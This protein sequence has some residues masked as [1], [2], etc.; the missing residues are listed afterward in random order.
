MYQIYILT[1]A[2]A[3]EYTLVLVIVQRSSEGFLCRQYWC[4]SCIEEIT[5]GVMYWEI[6]EKKIN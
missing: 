5:D 6:L 1:I 2:R 3:R 4:I